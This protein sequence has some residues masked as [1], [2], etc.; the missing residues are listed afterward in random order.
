MKRGFT[1]VLIAHKQNY[2]GFKRLY[3]IIVNCFRSDFVSYLKKVC[4]F[5]SNLLAE[6]QPGK[7]LNPHCTW[8]LPHD[9]KD[10]SW[11]QFCRSMKR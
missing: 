1:I 8:Q 9:D 4:L 10:D 7:P 3:K 6:F 2:R 11:S 5:S